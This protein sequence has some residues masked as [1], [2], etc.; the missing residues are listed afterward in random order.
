[1]KVLV[2]G[3][4]GFIGSHLC[5]RLLKE[6]YEVFCVDNLIT[7]NKRNI[8]DFLKNKKFHFI[9]EDI[10]KF[11]ISE[12]IKAIFHLASPASP[13]PESKLSYLNHPL[14]TLFANS[15]GTFHLLKLA[16]DNKA[17]FLFTSTSEIYGEPKI[18]PQPETYWG[19]VNPNGLR[20]CY[21]EAK[22]FGES[23]IMVFV[24]EFGVNARI[25]RLFNTYGS[26][27]DKNDGRVV[28]NFINQCIDKKPITIY[29]TGN[30]T[31]SFCYVDDTIDGIMKAMFKP[32]TKG[33][34]FNI[35][36]P[37]EKTIL[38]LAKMIINL[39]GSKSRII[40]RPAPIDDPTNRCPDI[41][42]AKSILG[43]Q[44]KIYLAEG[45]MRTFNYFKKG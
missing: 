34:I 21:D 32:N 10:C 33:E 40:Y 7:G 29:G 20:S 8:N 17:S 26:K 27:M 31:R 30:Q 9:N 23:M 38:T 25:V 42:K 4:A 13:N 1:M 16:N 24:K 35:G 2:A 36:N 6:G 11:T 28:V 37:D 19:N 12:N 15:M 18:S 41:Q 39:T 43:W 14:E 44:P 3:G 22:R 5:E 45:L